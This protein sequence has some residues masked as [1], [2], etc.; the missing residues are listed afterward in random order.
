MPKVLY[1][2]PNYVKLMRREHSTDTRAKTVGLT[3]A[4]KK[5]VQQ[6]VKAVE[7]V[8]ADFFAPLGDKVSTFNKQLL[9]LMGK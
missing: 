4:G 9:L 3:E 8:D 1:S 7:K 6:T 2:N 5:C